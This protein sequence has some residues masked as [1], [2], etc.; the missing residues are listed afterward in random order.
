MNKYV[1]TFQGLID[2]IRCGWVTYNIVVGKNMNTIRICGHKTIDK[3]KMKCLEE[4]C[5]VLKKCK[6]ANTPIS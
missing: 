1:I 2:D 4:L 3:K 6:K 5:P